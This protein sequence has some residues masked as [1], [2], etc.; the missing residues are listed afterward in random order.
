M[1]PPATPHGPPP[2]SPWSKRV[3]WGVATQPQAGPIDPYRAP[4]PQ[5]LPPP[6]HPGVDD[7]PWRVS[8]LTRTLGAQLFVGCFAALCIGALGFPP[9][10][11][12]YGKPS[13]GDALFQPLSV[14]LALG[15]AGIV[16][17]FNY[18]RAGTLEGTTTW[19]RRLK[20]LPQTRI[21]VDE[22]VYVS[23]TRPLRVRN[24][25]GHESEQRTLSFTV[26][27]ADGR[28]IS[29]PESA[30][31]R[32]P[33]LLQLFD[34][35]MQHAFMVVGESLSRGQPLVVGDVSLFHDRIAL[36]SGAVLPLRELVRIQ[37]TIGESALVHAID[38]SGRVVASLPDDAL[39]LRALPAL[40][41]PL[42]EQRARR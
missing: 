6:A 35:A 13:A 31:H 8:T 37:V 23:R 21:S 14:L 2:N 7:R 36:R 12:G 33:R 41:V 40:G 24:K 27:A 25:Y 29:I 5:P 19:L 42:D 34:A 18:A 30:V 22:V 28:A 10:D 38:R 20:P 39:L 1:H 16:L 15:A 11:T 4:P 26:V 3:P 32:Q 17:A 9:A